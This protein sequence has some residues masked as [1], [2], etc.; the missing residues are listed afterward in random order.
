MNTM[1][2]HIYIYTVLSSHN[3]N[4]KIIDGKHVINYEIIHTKTVR[5]K[6]EERR[7]KKYR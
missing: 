7:K 6:P 3:T 5:N 4:P 1:H 2:T